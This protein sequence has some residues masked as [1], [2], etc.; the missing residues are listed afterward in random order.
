MPAKNH[1]LDMTHTTR[2]ILPS[3]TF[4]PATEDSTK[5]AL[6]RLLADPGVWGFARW[7]FNEKDSILNFTSFAY[8][9]QEFLGRFPNSVARSGQG[10]GLRSAIRLI[11][12][13]I[14]SLSPLQ[15]RAITWLHEKSAMTPGWKG[16]AQDDAL[17]RLQ[18]WIQTRKQAG[19]TGGKRLEPVFFTRTA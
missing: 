6:K 15:I 5:K 9:T 17:Y 4:S 10:P 3:G 16:E 14:D 1:R 12:S 13:E 8:A 11:M 2:Y 18:A 7:R 19:F